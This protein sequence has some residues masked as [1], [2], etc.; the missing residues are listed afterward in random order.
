MR[1]LF[2]PARRA[3]YARELTKRFETVRTATLADLC[4]QLEAD[5]VQRQGEFVLVVEGAPQ[6][7]ADE[8]ELELQRV[9]ELLLDELPV[10]QAAKLAAKLTGAKRN[11]AYELALSLAN[12]D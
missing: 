10:K 9:V 12:K 1:D 2:G 7:D 4:T 6:A 5:E 8:H 3:C 11:R